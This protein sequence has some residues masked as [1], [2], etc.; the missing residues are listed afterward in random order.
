MTETTKAKSAKKP[1]DRKPK[2]SE[3]AEDQIV[4]IDFEGHEFTIKADKVLDADFL[5]A[6]EMGEVTPIGQVVAVIGTDGCKKLNDMVRDEDGRA[7]VEAVLEK[8]T[9]LMASAPVKN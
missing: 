4:T 6:S 8:F 3:R 1:T 7:S 5:L 2:A 9:E